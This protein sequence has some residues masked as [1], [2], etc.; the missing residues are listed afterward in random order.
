MLPMTTHETRQSVSS[1]CTCCSTHSHDKGHHSGCHSWG[2]VDRTLQLVTP[3]QLA[4]RNNESLITLFQFAVL[5]P[6]PPPTHTHI[7]TEVE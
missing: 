5:P 4:I 3:M 1:C 6:P 7:T 2:A